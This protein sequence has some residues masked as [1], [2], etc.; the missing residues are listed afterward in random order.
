MA[1][2]MRSDALAGGFE[3]GVVEAD[4]VQGYV[5]TFV[6][7]MDEALAKHRQALAA[8]RALGD[9]RLLANC[10]A[11]TSGT[12]HDV[13]VRK[14]PDSPEREQMLLESEALARELRD[15]LPAYS[16]RKALAPLL[17]ATA[18]TFQGRK[19][20]ALACYQE[21]QRNSLDLGTSTERMFAYI[22]ESEINFGWGNFERAAILY[23]AFGA[24]QE[25]MGYS[26][27]R[28][29]YVRT[30]WITRLDGSLRQALGASRYEALLR[31][32]RA[33]DP[34]IILRQEG[35]QR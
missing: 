12:L 5:A 13:A 18:L 25:R 28:A 23:G 29:Q 15:L 35:F 1:E 20:E 19:E 32:G 10:L 31:E 21:T 6:G 2:Q 26:L 9:R 34:G 4:V 8:G 11:H 14:S 3:P 22:F 7:A 16:R 17:L 24:L 33:A 27:E 30:D